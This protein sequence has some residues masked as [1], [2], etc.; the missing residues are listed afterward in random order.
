MGAA[1]NHVADGSGAHEAE[2]DHGAIGGADIA[3]DN[4][5]DLADETGRCDDHIVSILR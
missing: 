2:C 3:S 1:G 5:L 4:R